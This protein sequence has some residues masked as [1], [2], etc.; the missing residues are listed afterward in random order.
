MCFHLKSRALTVDVRQ[1]LELVRVEARTLP[2]DE[3]A[4]H[5]SIRHGRACNAVTRLH[6]L[7][8]RHVVA[9]L[10]T[11]RNENHII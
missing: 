9:T 6:F 8:V 3:V 11:K 7:L 5:A 10:K 2:S 1:R 4:E